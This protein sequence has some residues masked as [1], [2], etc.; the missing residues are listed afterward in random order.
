V[1][2]LTA[3][4]KVVAGFSAAHHA[5]AGWANDFHPQVPQLK[6]VVGRGGN[7]R[8]G[9][10]VHGGHCSMVQR[11][12]TMS[13]FLAAIHSQTVAGPAECKSWFDHILRYAEYRPKTN[14]DDPIKNYCP[15][16]LTIRN[17]AHLHEV[18]LEFGDLTVLV[19]P[20]GA[21]KSLAL[22][23]LKA[24]MDGKQI[25]DALKD[26]GH[27]AG[28]PDALIDLIFGT[29]MAPAWREGE[30][31]IRIDRK[32]VTPKT[33]GRIGNGTERLFFVP[34]HR[35][36]LISDGW[37]SPFQ[38]LTSDTPAVARIFSQNLFDRFSGK[39]AGTLFPVAKRL[40]REIREKIDQAVFHGGTVGI[41]ED[42]QHAR[43]LRLVHGKMHLPFMTWTAG[44][45]EFTPLLLGLYHLLPSVQLR[46][47]EGTDWV[48]IEEPEMG[49]HPQAVT[50]VMLLVLDL[51]WRGYKV[52]LS[53]HSPHV[54]TMLWMMRQLKDHQ[55][56]WQLVCEAFDVETSPPMHKVAAEALRKEYRAHLLQ[57]GDNGKV[58]SKDISALDPSSADEHVAGW[59]G[60][61]EYSS[62]FGDAV[63]KAV[64]EDQP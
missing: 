30:T 27:P 1:Q 25:V 9:G 40:K 64:N 55:A 3:Q 8:G 51:M 42:H 29:G 60:L 21:G 13:G 49:L 18:K 16:N 6:V 31:D 17:F 58:S 41:E 33:I 56:R 57:F 47:R 22:Q 53:T 19:G 52:V 43:R 61:T 14:L 46:K 50:A 5:F 59:G 4:L 7:R 32:R 39:D 23:W 12:F 35:S 20:Q 48:V 38:K 24:A 28:R 54:L 2:H 44:Q 37:A 36:M 63:R 15:M 11:V 10:S 26:A 45:R 62:R 34:A